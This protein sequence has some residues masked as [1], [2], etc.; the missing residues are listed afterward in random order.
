MNKRFRIFF[1]VILYFI[2]LTY[3]FSLVAEEKKIQLD[4]EKSIQINNIIVQNNERID[5]ETIISYLNLKSGDP[6]NYKILNRKLKEMYNL[7]L[8]LDI[9]FRVS[10]NDLIVIIKEN[11]MI[12]NVNF[13]GN[14]NLKEDV[15]RE[16]ISLKSRSVYQKKELQD[17]VN[18]VQDLYKRSGFFSAKIKTTISKLSQNRIDIT[19]NINEGNKT[20]IKNVKFIG[21]KIFSDR[22]LK[23]IISTKESKLWRI[24]SSGDIYDP[25]RINYDKD[26]LRRYYL[27]EGYADFKIISA[28]A[29]LT[30]DKSGFFL[31][32]SLDE[33][34]KYKFGKVTIDNQNYKELKNEEI[35]EFTQKIEGKFYNITKLDEVMGGILVM[36]F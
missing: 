6:V 8:F 26:L 22:R 28:V 19:I 31:T 17:A 7:G 13:V 24:L 34:K 11:P 36:L 30:K 35:Q 18:V 5:T 15:F 1:S 3:N 33:G 27:E 20:K 32:Y 23:G 29:E 12:N 10:N 9:K 16:E 2:F 21:N 4:T 14:K 25:D